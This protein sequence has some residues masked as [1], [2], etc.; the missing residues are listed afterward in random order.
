MDALLEVKFQA[1]GV[2]LVRV[3][4]F[5]EVIGPQLWS[6]CVAKRPHKCAES[7]QTYAPGALVYRPVGNPQNRSQR[8]LAKYI[9]TPNVRGNAGPTAGEEA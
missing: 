2:A 8:I 5:G 1:P 4:W 6:R 9:E 7:G 3:K